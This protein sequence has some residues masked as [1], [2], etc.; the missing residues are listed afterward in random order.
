[1]AAASGGLIFVNGLGAILGPITLGPLMANFGPNAFFWFIG[2][3]IATI[4]I[5]AVYRST[6]RAAPA[7]EDT[8][9]YAAVALT[10]SPVAVEVAQEVAIEMAIEAEEEAAELAEA[11]AQ[12]EPEPEPEPIVE[13]KPKPKRT[14]KK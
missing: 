5:I 9:A 3:L 1:M 10:S 13:E 6:Q 8:S 2:G 11:E 14:R 4:T 12:L 7:V